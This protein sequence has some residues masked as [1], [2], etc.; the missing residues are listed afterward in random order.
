MHDIFVLTHPEWYSTKYVLTHAP[1]LRLQMRTAS[2]LI[3]VS[4]PVS[5]QVREL[6]KNKKPV[7]VA[8]NAPASVF[9]KS[10]SPMTLSSVLG[11]LLLEPGKYILSV[12]SKDPRKNLRT[13]VRSYLR[14]PVELREQYPLVLVGGSSSVFASVD[15]PS[16]P[17]VR[18]LGYVS[19]E[20][21]A[22]LYSA[23]NFVAFPSLDEGFGLPAV[24]ALSAGARLLVSDVEVMRWVCEEFAE[25]VDPRNE[26]SVTGGLRSLLESKD[27]SSS[28]DARREY[29]RS[30]FTWHGSAAA[31][32]SRLDDIYDL[33][34]QD[35]STPSSDYA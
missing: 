10:V 31:I 21:L 2:I 3:A 29:A 11:R 17:S 16:D 14:L 26:Q 34:L 9:S 27:S 19:D 12:A 8:P 23:A 18:H 13:L 25:Y 1:I 22:A 24:E 4:E 32:A 15:I 30:R 28:R 5:L 7:I 20:D 6:T 35:A 33:D